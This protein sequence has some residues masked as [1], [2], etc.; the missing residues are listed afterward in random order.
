MYKI[1]Y[2]DTQKAYYLDINFN[3]EEEAREYIEENNLNGAYDFYIIERTNN[4][5]YKK[6]I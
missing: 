5:W 6:H 3:N 1:K 2:Q 4:D